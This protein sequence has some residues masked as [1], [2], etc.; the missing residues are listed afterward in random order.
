L[1]I[2][3]VDEVHRHH[4]AQEPVEVEN[5]K[6]ELAVLVPGL[7]CQH[8]VHVIVQIAGVIRSPA[9]QAQVYS[10]IDSLIA[11]I[12]STVDIEHS[13]NAFVDVLRREAEHM[14]VKPVGAHGFMPIA[15]NFPDAPATVRPACV[16]IRCGSVNAVAPCQD[17]WIVV[18]VK[19]SGKE[20]RSGETIVF[21]AMMAVMLMGGNRVPPK[22]SVLR[23]VCG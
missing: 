9:G 13:G 14:I 6:E 16:G 21:S 8:E 17:D 23:Y 11:A 20:K 4:V 5:I 18:V 2:R 19:L 15:R 12:Q 3:T 10:V 7:V 1:E 22:T